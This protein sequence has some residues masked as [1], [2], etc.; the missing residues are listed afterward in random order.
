[1][2]QTVLAGLEIG[3]D[4]YEND[5]YSRMNA[6]PSGQPAS[7]S[8]IAPINL[9]NPLYEDKPALSATLV[10]LP[11]QN[12]QT[13]GDAVAAYINDQID[14]TVHW[15][16]ALGLR[17]D[18]FESEQKQLASTY[19]F[20]TGGGAPTLA[21]AATRF[22]RTDTAWSKRAGLIWQPG[23][24]QSY[25]VSFGTSFNPSA[26]ALTLTLGTAPLAPEKNKSYEAG[27]KWNLIDNKLLLTSA[28]FRV[29]KENA[30]TTDIA[31]VQTLDGDIRVD[32]F[33]VGATGQLW[34]GLQI[35]GGYTYLNGEILKSNDVTAGG[36]ISAKGKIPNNVPKHTAS[37][38]ATYRWASVWELG[39]GA[40]SSS[41]RYVNNFQTAVID[42]YTRLD[43]TA[44]FIQPRYDVRINILNA[45]DRKYFETASGGRATPVAG[46][47]AILSSN[48]RF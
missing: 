41:K 17:W 48:Y 6:T 36:A 35:T 46:R 21:L 14:I 42:G 28:V 18:R 38:W 12:T 25:Y 20:P 26:E 30:R 22:Q 44:A 7:I 40:V 31:G 24:Q 11:T 1:V 34:R 27:A 16:I 4:E 8:P 9:G 5:T 45:T 29:E 2:S 47:T 3:R 10:R 37:L 23:E 19:T 32:G 15:K 39:G 43:A 13:D 33:E